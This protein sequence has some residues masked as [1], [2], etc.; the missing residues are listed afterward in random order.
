MASC[1]AAKSAGGVDGNYLLSITT[2]SAAVYCAMG[3]KKEAPKTY[4]LLPSKPVGPL[5]CGKKGF[6]AREPSRCAR[7]RAC[8]LHQHCHHVSQR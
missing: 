7:E 6:A 2:P 3:T 1:S 4:L 5:D 8:L